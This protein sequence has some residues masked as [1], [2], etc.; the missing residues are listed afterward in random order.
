MT[1]WGKLFRRRPRQTG[2]A[3]KDSKS[4]A[5]MVVSDK[6]GRGIV[7]EGCE[8]VRDMSLHASGTPDESYETKEKLPAKLHS[9]DINRTLVGGNLIA[10]AGDVFLPQLP[11]VA[12]IHQIPPPPKDFVGRTSELHELSAVGTRDQANLFGLHGMPGVGKTVLARKL[13]ETL[14][15]LFPGGHLNIDLKGKT[16]EPLTVCEVMIYVI[17]SFLPTVELPTDESAIAGFYQSVLH[18]KRVLL[19]MDDATSSEQI[20]QLIP[21]RGCGMLITSQEQL[22]VPG[23]VSRHITTLRPEDAEALLLTIAPRLGEAAKEIAR[24]CENLP[25]ALRLAGGAIATQPDLVPHDYVRILSDDAHKLDL[26]A[27]VMK[28]SYDLLSKDA[29]ANWRALSIF[30]DSFDIAAAGAI[31]HVDR[32]MAAEIMNYLV[33]HNLVEWNES[34]NRYRLHHLLRVFALHQV[35]NEERWTSER[36]FFNFF[37]DIFFQSDQLYRRGGAETIVGLSTFDLERTNIEAAQSWVIAHAEDNDIAAQAAA[38]FPLHGGHVLR[39]RVHPSK[40]IE[41]YEVSL[42][43]ARRIRD[44]NLTGSLSYMIGLTYL[45]LG[46]SKK[47]IS[48]HREYLS[49]GRRLNDLSMQAAAFTALGQASDNL[50]QYERAISM[51]E[52]ALTLSRKL[53][54]RTAESTELLYLGQAHQSLRR[55]ASA[56]NCLLSSLKIARELQIRQNEG[57]ALAALAALHLDH[58]CEDAFRFSRG[59]LDIFRKLGYRGGEAGVLETLGRLRVRKGEFAEG[60]KLQNEAVAIFR[61]IGDTIGENKAVG[62]IGN[63]YAENGHHET[64]VSYYQRQV[65]TALVVGD[66]QGEGNGHINMAKSLISI[67]MA[68]EAVTEA[69]TAL[70]IFRDLR[71]AHA[72][73][74]GYAVLAEAYSSMKCTEMATECYLD[75]IR[76]A[77][78]IGH[79]LCEAESHFDMAKIFHQIGAKADA[80]VCAEA[81]LAIFVKLDSAVAVDVREQLREWQNNKAGPRSPIK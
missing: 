58:A 39:M 11:S 77:R 81:S 6:S 4:G 69:K 38:N 51:F 67:G 35:S 7:V 42:K 65:N 63:S 5:Q 24:I 48:Y 55:S 32:P 64:A 31:W 41:L 20:G 22:A 60:L 61:D 57:S 59:A 17:R 54:D 71:L 28:L 33:R 40:R 29:K 27:A 56:E 12:S 52:Q 26:I 14:S 79:K 53:N 76:F 8:A 45:E 36:L 75:R 37:L 2:V 73:C 3:V 43:A 23:M 70:D 19:L 49:L 1:F 80:R 66:I 9:I 16:T 18:E 30:A 50:G 68:E 78:L 46:D 44:D 72:E 34:S 25:F 10:V 74:G 21:P 15:F 47:A 62:N 13:A